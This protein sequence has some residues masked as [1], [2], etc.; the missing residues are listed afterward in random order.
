MFSGIGSLL[1][2]FEPKLR[3]LLKIVGFLGFALLGFSNAHASGT[4]ITITSVSPTTSVATGISTITLNGSGFTGVSNVKFGAN[5]HGFSIISDSQI[6]LDVGPATDL[7]PYDIQVSSATDSATATAAFSFTA[8]APPVVTS[9]SPSSGSA[10]GGT[11]ITITGSGFTPAISNLWGFNC[12]KCGSGYF[13]LQIG[14]QIANV[15]SFTSTEIVATLPTSYTLGTVEIRVGNYFNYGSLAGAFTYTAPAPPTFTSL[16]T[17]SGSAS[18]GTS[19]TVTGTGLLQV[20]SL[21]MGGNTVYVSPQSDV[22]FTFTTPQANA[23]GSTS[24]VLNT[25]WSSVTIPNAF[26]YTK[27]PSPTITSISPDSG[28]AAG[29]TLVTTT[30]TGL[31]GLTQVSLGGVAGNIY[32]LSD[33]QASFY[34]PSSGVL[35]PVNLKITTTWE[36]STVTSAFTYT[37][38][39]SPTISSLSPNSIAA[40]VQARVMINGTNLG[41][42][43]KITFGGVPV[44]TWAQNSST[45]LTVIPNPSNT[46]GSV[47]VEITTAWDSVTATSAFTFTKPPSPTI[48]SISP[49]T[50]FTSGSTLVTITGTGLGNISS[51]NFGEKPASLSS[52]SDNQITVYSPSN[53][54]IGAVDV[55][56]NNQW[57]SAIATSSFTYVKPPPIVISS[58]SP[59]TAVATAGTTITVIGSGLASATQVKFGSNTY[60]VN[61]ISDSQLQFSVGP[62]INLGP[63]DIQVSNISD[64]ATATAAFSFTAPT[65]PVVTSISPSSGSAAGGSTITITGSGFTPTKGFVPCLQACGMPEFFYLSIG[66]AYASV[67]SWS[68]TQI[69]ATLPVSYTLGTA[70]IR[71]GNYFNYGSLAGAFTYTAP[72]PPTLTSLSTTSGSASGGTS[73]TVTGTGLLQVNS[74]SMGGN[75]VYVSPQ[76]DVQFTFTTPQANALGSTSFVLNTPWSSVTIPNAF[77]YTKPPSPTITSISPDSGSAAGQTLVTI[78]GTGLGNSSV[79]FGTSV[80]RLTKAPTETQIQAYAP[81]NISLG[82][83]DVKVVT[84]WDSVTAAGAFT[85]IK[86]PSPTITSISPS[87]AAANGGTQVVING[88]GFTAWCTTVFIGTATADLMDCSDNQLSLYVP[89]TT[90]MGPVDVIVNNQWDSVTAVKGFTY[91]APVLPIISSLS[92]SHISAVGGDFL[93]LSGKNLQPQYG[94]NCP[95]CGPGFYDLQVGGV[96]AKVAKSSSNEVQFYSP[97]LFA[98]GKIDVVLKT[99]WGVVALNDAL[100]VDLPPPPALTSL[101]SAH[102]SASGGEL[103]TLTG[104]GFTQ[105]TGVYFGGLESYKYAINS[106]TQIIAITP[107]VVVNQVVDVTVSTPWAKSTLANAYTF[108]NGLPSPPAG[109]VGVSINNGARYT[110]SSNVSLNLVWPFGAGSVTVSNDGGFL[111]STSQV[112]KLQSPIDWTLSP[113]AVVPLPAIVYVRFDND[114]F[115]YFDDIIVDSTNPILTFAQAST[116]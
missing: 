109:S 13:Y 103:V 69:T 18:G 4:G 42:I 83:I 55:I 52:L 3:T 16:S 22:Q 102:G 98:S 31:A 113:R 80:G 75:T 110:N 14:S 74:L 43:S 20:N 15:I 17:T 111:P 35:G 99:A 84:P 115:T 39:S 90:T 59:V 5:T 36:S 10:A 104:S 30:G 97:Q 34:S 101:Y 38:P 2:P 96:S 76:S 56:V 37:K 85:Y 63:F 116:R 61:R 71:V 65:P 48:S 8:P 92:K 72:A 73:V 70:E 21:S 107:N 23:L 100:S 114:G 57:G 6:R 82:Q 67:T 58:V 49:N 9:I 62:S 19:V 41:S 77:T 53:P 29:Q 50:G 47:D 108:E 51:V 88:T 1:A 91:D 68:S 93:V 78:T 11:T 89:A 94:Y 40:G 33:T 87:H 25:P 112:F 54:S 66:G 45:E 106:D 46:V 27:P 24:F 7:G 26:T 105:A 12:N 81:M 32:S 86:P 28:S 79:I 95:G 60:G 44:L 64:S